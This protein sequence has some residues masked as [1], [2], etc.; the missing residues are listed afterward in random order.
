MITRLDDNKMGTIRPS[1][2][3]FFLFGLFTQR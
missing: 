2:T 3:I 1:V